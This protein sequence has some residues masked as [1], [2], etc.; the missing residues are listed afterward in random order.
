[1]E[2]AVLPGRAAAGAAVVAAAPWARGRSAPA[3][4]PARRVA[5]GR[6]AGGR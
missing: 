4:R 1:M 6:G 3:P 5:A 2:L